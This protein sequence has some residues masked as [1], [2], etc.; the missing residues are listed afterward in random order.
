[1]SLSLSLLLSASLTAL[2]ATLT[3]SGCSSGNTTVADAALPAV[4]PTPPNIVFI[5]ADDLGM[6]DLSVYGSTVISTP[7]IDALAEP[8]VK[9]TEGYA[10]SQP[11]GL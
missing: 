6:G 3:L 9:F 7:H 2:A 8:G 5:F 1:M 10:T 11:N 4:V